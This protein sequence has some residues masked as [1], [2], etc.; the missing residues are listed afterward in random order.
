MTKN[1]L[2]SLDSINNT[3]ISRLDSLEL[4]LNKL[5]NISQKELE[6]T[7]L[8]DNDYDF[9]NDF[10]ERLEYVVIGINEQGKQTTVIADVHTDTNTN[11]VLEEGVGYV[12]IILACY[13]DENNDIKIAAGTVFS[14]YEFKHPMDDRLTDEKWVE[15]LEANQTPERPLWIDS[16][17]HE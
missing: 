12:D 17:Y 14:Y 8:S 11:M 4:I 3:E 7:E 5:I 15:L 10:G 2:I 6:N 1:G 9:I 13:S 16:F